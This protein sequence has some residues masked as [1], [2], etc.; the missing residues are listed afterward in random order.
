MNSATLRSII[1][2]CGGISLF[3]R[4]AQE[5]YRRVRYWT[6][7]E[8]IPDYACDTVY[9]VG[10]DYARSFAPIGIAQHKVM[11]K[12]YKSPITPEECKQNAQVEFAQ[13]AHL[14]EGRL[15]LVEWSE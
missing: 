3:A 8:N 4:I 6:Q 5:P 15:F 11:P 9:K 13:L 10:Y 12:Y 7:T 1:N 2:M 14:Q